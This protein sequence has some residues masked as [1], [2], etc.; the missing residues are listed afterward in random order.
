MCMSFSF[1]NLLDIIISIYFI[2][3]Y[4]NVWTYLYECIYIGSFLYGCL[5]VHKF[6]IDPVL[7]GVDKNLTSLSYVP[8]AFFFCDIFDE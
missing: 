8:V 6:T 2:Y 1:P 7:G 4:I 5:G 3:V